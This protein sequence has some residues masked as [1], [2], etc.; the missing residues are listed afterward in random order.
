MLLSILSFL[1]KNWA[2]L[3]LILVGAAALFVY[4]LQERKKE[5]EAASLIVQQIDELQDRL[6]EIQSYIVNGQLNETGFYESQE[7]I[8]EDYWNKYK[9]YF[10]RKMDDKSYRTL[11]SL[12]NCV[13]EIQEQQNLMKKKK[14]NHFFM[15]QQVISNLETSYILDGLRNSTK[16]PMDNQQVVS[17]LMQSAPQN[18][19]NEQRISIEN[20]LHSVT[21]SNSVTDFNMFWKEYNQKVEW[22]RS[23]IDKNGLTEYIPLQ[24]RMSLEK[25]LSQYA[26]LEITGSDGYIRLKRIAGRRM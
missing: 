17:A 8:N 26:L 20:M 18:L 15:T 21:E 14:K 13:Y 5:T 12:Y 4:I 11:N 16:Y 25:A 19:T 22:L 2:N 6:K 24:I 10:I 3:L 9:H 1:S 23:I 7:V